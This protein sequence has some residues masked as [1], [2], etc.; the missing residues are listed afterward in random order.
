MTRFQIINTLKAQMKHLQT[1]TN[2]N[3]QII[4]QDNQPRIIEHH[5][6]TS[7]DHIILTID[8]DDIRNGLSENQWACTAIDI[9]QILKGNL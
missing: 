6:V 1:H 9:E 4:I 8:D 7:K 3:Q 2:Y 5:Y